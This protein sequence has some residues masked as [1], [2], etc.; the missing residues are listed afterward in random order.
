MSQVLHPGEYFIELEFDRPVDPAVLHRALTGMGFGTVVFDQ[1]LPSVN[2]GAAPLRQVST[3]TASVR[4]PVTVQSR[5]RAPMTSAVQ[6]LATVKVIDGGPPAALKPK[7]PSLSMN[8]SVSPVRLNPAIQQRIAPA[9]VRLQT[10][11][12]AGLSAIVTPYGNKGGG[13]NPSPVSATSPASPA[14]DGGGGGGASPGGSSSA[15]SADDGA[16]PSDATD[17]GGDGSPS[18]SQ[19]V[20]PPPNNAPGG[21]AADDE[22]SA[23]LVLQDRWQRWKE[24]G[25]PYATGP[26]T[27]TSGAGGDEDPLRFR[28]LAKLDRPILLENRPGMRWLF[29]KPLTFS[30]LG[31]LVFQANPFTLRQGATYEFRFL[32]RAKSNPSRESVKNGL[33]EMGFAPVKLSAI[34]RN[35]TLPRRAASLTLWYGMG[36]W[37]HADSVIIHDD[38][39]FFET[40]K[41]IAS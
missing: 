16:S 21:N 1:S 28:V 41:E 17:G 5:Y 35:I 25:S 12:G 15:S 10:P 30:F 38:P 6:K 22:M 18:M 7:S 14:D 29:V 13:G 32:S 19:D 20:P 2:V 11:G 34:K 23:I 9:N 37:S 8:T 40:V 36:V 24:W 27:S 31:D 33:A 4:A 39:F 3:S 26:G